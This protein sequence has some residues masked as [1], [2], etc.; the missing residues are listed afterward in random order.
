MDNLR[1]FSPSLDWGGEL[2]H[3]LVWIGKAWAIA[4]VS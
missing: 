4:A 3:S 2:L 1:P